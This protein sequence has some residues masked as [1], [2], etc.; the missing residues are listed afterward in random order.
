MRKWS[1]S[2]IL[3]SVDGFYASIWG[4]GEVMYSNIVEGFFCFLGVC[5]L[6]GGT[7]V[8]CHGQ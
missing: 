6:W 5:Y 7:L 3:G 2:D 1:L 8:Y 4:G